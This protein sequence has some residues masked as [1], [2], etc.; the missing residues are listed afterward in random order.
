[1]MLI[2]C[3]AAAQVPTT[4]SGVPR[5]VNYAR[6]FPGTGTV[7]G[8]T[9]GTDLTGGGTTGDAKLNLNKTATD[10]HYA[11]LSASHSF[12]GNKTVA[13]MERVEVR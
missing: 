12:T 2:T 6:V 5:L 1:M 9:A 10:A 8:V 11:Q 4:D 7:T 3:A 13:E